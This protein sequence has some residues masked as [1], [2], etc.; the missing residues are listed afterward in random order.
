MALALL[1]LL[2]L[3]LLVATLLLREGDLLTVLLVA[4]RV[5][6]LCATD[7]WVLVVLL[8]T[9]L[10]WVL[11]SGFLYVLVLLV[12]VLLRGVCVTVLLVTAFRCGDLTV[13]DLFVTVLLF[14]GLASF[15]RTDLLSMFLDLSTAVLPATFALERFDLVPV[16]FILS[17]LVLFDLDDL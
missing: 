11:F 9:F 3:L 16:F 1:L 10:L 14:D 6:G 12:T 4:L 2:L 5:E 17:F 15:L 8:R 13:V 7:F